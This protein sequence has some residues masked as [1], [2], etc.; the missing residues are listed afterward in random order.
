MEEFFK[1]QKKELQSMTETLSEMKATANEILSLLDEQG[2]PEPM[3]KPQTTK[4][5]ALKSGFVVIRGGAL[6]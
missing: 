5:R 3:R 4:E 2:F 1:E 6:Q